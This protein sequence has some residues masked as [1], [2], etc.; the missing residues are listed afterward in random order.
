MI[1][2]LCGS[3]NFCGDIKRIRDELKEK[4]HT[5]YSLA[6]TDL[7][8]QEIEAKKNNREDRKSVV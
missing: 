8:F 5:V 1:I 2:T 6:W 3:T 4:G 7:S